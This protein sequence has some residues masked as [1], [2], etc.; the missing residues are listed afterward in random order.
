MKVIVK[1]IQTKG[2]LDAPFESPFTFTLTLTF[3]AFPF[4]GL[5]NPA[6]EAGARE[7]VSRC[8]PS[9]WRPAC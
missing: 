7:T 2:A 9:H 1:V 5:L 3:P 4:P 8:I 6:D